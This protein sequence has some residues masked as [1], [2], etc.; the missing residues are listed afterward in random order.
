[1]F[2]ASNNIPVSSKLIKYEVLFVSL[3]EHHALVGAPR[4]EKFG[5]FCVKTFGEHLNLKLDA[6]AC[7]IPAAGTVGQQVWA[8][9]GKATADFVMKLTRQALKDMLSCDQCCCA[10]AVSLSPLMSCFLYD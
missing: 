9:S 5:N 1:M 8:T 4:N 7:G 2:S 10:L 3:R 6:I